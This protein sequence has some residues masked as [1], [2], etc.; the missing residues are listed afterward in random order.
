MKTLASRMFRH[1]PPHNERHE[2]AW[3]FVV[4]ALVF[5]ASVGFCADGVADMREVETERP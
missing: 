1:D 4:M 3:A 2:W 5:V